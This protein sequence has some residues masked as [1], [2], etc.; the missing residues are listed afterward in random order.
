ML[1]NVLSLYNSNLINK[2]IHNIYINSILDYDGKEIN[3]SFT[4]TKKDPIVINKINITGNSITKNETIR[5]KISIEPG[6]YFNNFLLDKSIKNLERYPY[7]KDVNS[8]TNINNQLVDITLDIDEETKT[9]NS[10]D[11]NIRNKKHNKLKNNSR[12]INPGYENCKT[13]FPKAHK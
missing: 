2:N 1:D 11:F 6:Q 5:S 10:W 3:L 7:I 4:A 9:G 13:N 8:K 12:F